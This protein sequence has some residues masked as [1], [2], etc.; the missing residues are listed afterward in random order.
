MGQSPPAVSG[1]VRRPRKLKELSQEGLALE[2][3]ISGGERVVRNPTPAII[4]KFAK[5]LD[6]LQ[7]GELLKEESNP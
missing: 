5:A 1:N 6:D 3:G 4:A 2:T 7:P